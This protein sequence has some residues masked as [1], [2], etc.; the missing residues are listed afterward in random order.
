[1]PSLKNSISKGLLIPLVACGGAEPSSSTAALDELRERYGVPGLVAVAANPENVIFAGAAGATT[2]DGE[3][4]TIHSRFHVGS[5]SK[6]ISATA[7]ALAVAEGRLTWD[8]PLSEVDPALFANAHPAWRDIT[9]RQL[10]SH[11]AGVAPFEEDEE[12]LAF[13]PTTSDGSARRR[14]FAA[15]ILATEPDYAPGSQHQYSNAGYTVLASVMEELYRTDFG[16]RVASS[17]FDPLGMTSAGAGPPS[18]AHPDESP[19]HRW[20]PSVSRYLQYQ[21]PPEGEL[22]RDLILPAG[23]FH[24]SMVDLAMF[25]AEHVNGLDSAGVLLSREDYRDLHQPVLDD[26]AMGWNVRPT[27]DSHVGGLEGWHTAALIVM[28]DEGISYAVAVNA[29]LADMTL[30]SE[31]IAMLREAGY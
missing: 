14:E 9:P 15:W 7:I 3:A 8:G 20:D 2:L 24:L 6:P 27:S 23:D 26:Y 31:V 25:G 12:F 4:L 21:D 10:L 13:V 11:T 5:V 28:K 30:F 19:G 22:I 18:L 29:E 17:V 1:M 16:A